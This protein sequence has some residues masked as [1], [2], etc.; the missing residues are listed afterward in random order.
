M[1]RDSISCQLQEHSPTCFR[2]QNISRSS[3]DAAREIKSLITWNTR[4]DHWDSLAGKK[5]AQ[6]LPKGNVSRYYRL[7][8]RGCLDST[9]Y[10]RG[11]LKGMP[12]TLSR[13][14]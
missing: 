11:A 13:M 3:I 4:E 8:I 14:E 7:S 5:M 6:H 1:R 12:V 2:R 9:A 10:M